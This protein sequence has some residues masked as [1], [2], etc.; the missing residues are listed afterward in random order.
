MSQKFEN[1]LTGAN[2]TYSLPA[3]TYTLTGGK[4]FRMVQADN[5]V[6]LVA[7]MRG[8]SPVITELG[9]ADGSRFVGANYAEGTGLTLLSGQQVLGTWDQI[10]ITSGVAWVGVD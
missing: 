7:K 5:G 9:A 8:N 10:V 6:S 1:R 4:R 2:A 3:G